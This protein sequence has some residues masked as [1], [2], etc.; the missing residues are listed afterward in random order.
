MNK[1]E[2]GAE[3]FVDLIARAKLGDKEAF[4]LLY[5][6]YLTPLYRFVYR[7]TKSKVEAEDIVQETFV[8]AFLALPKYEPKTQDYLP[9]LYT[10]ARNLLI[11]QNRRPKNFSLD[12]LSTEPVAEHQDPI[13]L[14][15]KKEL[16]KQISRALEK[17]SDTEK[18]AIELRF[19]SELEYFEIAKIL[20]KEESAIRKS[21]SRGMLRLRQILKDEDLNLK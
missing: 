5:Q 10:V 1:S 8:R 6:R 11:N 9:F 20:N 15:Q 18:T 2:E 3:D 21:V 17:L 16:T 12:D 7:R 4:A 14:A 19:L 13:K